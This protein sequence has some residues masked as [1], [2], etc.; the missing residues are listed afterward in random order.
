MNAF[1]TATSISLLSAESNVGLMV[2]LAVFITLTVLLAAFI[3]LMFANKSFR[4]F[5]MRSDKSEESAEKRDEKTKGKKRNAQKTAP[6][7]KR[8]KPAASDGW[9]AYEGRVETVPLDAPISQ[10]PKKSRS[11]AASAR[12][13]NKRAK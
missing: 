13:G 3:V 6:R 10:T 9:E 12:G 2:A 4:A 11:S 7:A 8:A 5:F 1:V